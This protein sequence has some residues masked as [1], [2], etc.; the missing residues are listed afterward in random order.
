M[1][2]SLWFIK[3]A[4]LP[5]LYYHISNRR[6]VRISDLRQLEKT[7]IKLT[8]LS[9]DLGYFEK[10]IELGL[11]PKFLKFRPP[12]LAAYKDT[13]TVY[14]QVLRNQIN[15]VKKEIK[16]VNSKYRLQ[17]NA[18]VLK[19]SILERLKLVYLLS[20]RYKNVSK[21]VLHN[22]DKKLLHLWKADRWKSPDCLINLSKKKLTTTEE[23]VL[24]F[25]LK[26][27]IHPKKVDSVMLMSS[28]ENVIENVIKE[29]YP[30][31]T[32]KNDKKFVPPIILSSDFKDKLKSSFNSFIHSSNGICQSKQNQAV[33]QTLLSLSKDKNIKVCKFD[34]GNGVIIL[35]SNDYF[36]KLDHIVLDDS[37]FKLV[38]VGDGEHPII[39]A[40]NSLKKNL[41]KFSK[42]NEHCS[43]LN[44]LKPSGSQPGKLYGLCKA[45]KEGYPLRPVVSMLGT[46][47]YGLAKYLR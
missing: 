16:S 32:D 26:H 25:G 37:K 3:Y 21:S 20:V 18:V 22:H 31:P 42:E 1:L 47:E 12:K 24:R 27:H 28:I 6:D 2:F 35:N 44:F 34:K 29:K 17:K 15:I 7:G 38:D 9:L 5:R 40:E 33:H 14:Q 43:F 41:T 19:I 46:A 39:T 13:K 45:H 4:T 30:P 10:C 36:N 8:K 11:C 23:N